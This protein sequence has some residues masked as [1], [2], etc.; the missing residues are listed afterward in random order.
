[1][2]ISMRLYVCVSVCMYILYVV[3]VFMRSCMYL[4]ILGTFIVFMH[5]RVMYV[6][7]C[8]CFFLS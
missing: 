5:M 1:L 6:C 3:R 8:V 4:F 7:V 2:P